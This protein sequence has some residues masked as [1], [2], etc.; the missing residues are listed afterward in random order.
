MENNGKNPNG[1]QGEGSKKHNP[2]QG[3]SRHGNHPRGA[4]GQGVHTQQAKVPRDSSVLGIRKDEQKKNQPP[5]LCVICDKP[6]FDLA[7]ALS[8]KD[9]GNPVHFDCALERVSVAET[10]EAG[11]KIVY[12]GAGCFGV[13]EYRKGNDGSFVVKRRIRW[14]KEG[15]KQTWRRDLS[16]YITRI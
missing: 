4:H 5:Q 13:V 10:L 2:R 3:Q 12:L 11:E 6:I 15:E 1:R 7:G 8:D 9:S 14:E 16:S